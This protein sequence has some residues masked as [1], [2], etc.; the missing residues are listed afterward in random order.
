MT[1]ILN[2]KISS[3]GR[4]FTG[5]FIISLKEEIA[6]KKYAVI[7]YETIGRS[8]MVGWKVGDFLSIEVNYSIGPDAIL[9]KEIC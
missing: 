5:C 7:N 4:H 3:E 6:K 9:V 2:G 8:K 1:T